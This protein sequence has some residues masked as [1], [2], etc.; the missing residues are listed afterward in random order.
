MLKVHSHKNIVWYDF[1]KPEKVDFLPLA[2]KFNI[3]PYIVNKFLNSN[4]RDKVLILG[5]HFF[6]SISIPEFR[7]VE[8]EYGRQELKFIIGN[9]YLISS[10]NSPNKGIDYFKKIFNDHSYFE[11]SK[12]SENPVVYTF[13]HLM[14]KVYANM[15]YELKEISKEIDRV[16][17]EIFNNNEARVVREISLINRKLIDYGKNISG[18]K[19]TWDLFLD[20][21]KEFFEKEQSHDA[22]ESILL[23][24]QRVISEWRHLKQTLHELRDTNN[25]LLN[26]KLND[27]TKTFT[28]IAF[29][30]L[31]ITLF[32]S[33]LSIPTKQ[34]YFLGSNENDFTVVV[35]IS[36]SL[37]LIMLAISKIKRWW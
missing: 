13:L 35:I 9:G 34:Q 31:P 24:Y 17:R 25:S 29:L 11:K 5:D 23:S 12:E 32:A 7:E 19:N 33:I 30:T 14:E 16:E 6:L 1:L 21:S 26:S 20:L 18:H 15:I 10:T 2:E 8:G 36:L 37:F 28:L 27:T 3:D 4:N 22:L